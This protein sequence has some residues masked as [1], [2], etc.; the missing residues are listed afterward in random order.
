MNA[1]RTVLITVSLL[2]VA[3]TVAAQPLDL[4]PE[5]VWTERPSERPVIDRGPVG[6][7]DTHTIDSLFLFADQSGLY[8]FYT[9][10]DKPLDHG[11]R[12]RIGLAISHDGVHWEKCETN[13]VVVEGLPG[14][15]DSVGVKGPVVARRNDIYYL[16]YT[17]GDGQT[18]QIG[19]ATSI[20]LA[21][22]TKHAGNPVLAGRPGAWD[23][24]LSTHPVPVFKR[25]KRFH[26]LYRGVASARRRQGL[27][28]AVSSNLRQWERLQEEPV[29]PPEE[30]IAS[31][32]VVRARA[33]F[34]GIA[35]ASERAYWY[36]N[37][38]V[39]W[40][41]GGPPQFTGRNVGRLS[42][43]IL[44][45]GEWIMLYGRH[46]RIYRAVSM[47][48]APPA[49]GLAINEDNSHFFGS[50]SADEMTLEGLHAFVDQ[51]ASTRV[52]DLFLCPNAMRTS[53]RSEVWDPIW[54]VGDQQVPEDSEFAQ[55]WVSNARLLDERGLDPYAVWI[56]R[57]REKGIRPWLS[58]RMNDVHDV[59][60]LTSFM[61]STFW[62]EHPEYWRVPGSTGNW[63][64][65]AFDYAIPEV[66]EHHLKLIRELLE[67]YDPAGIELDWMRFGYHFKPGHEGEGRRILTE[68]ME[69]VHRLTDEWSGKRGHPIKLGARVPAHPDAAR[70][71]GMAAVAWARQGLVDMLV[72]T[73]FWSTSD[74]DIPME[75][76]RERIGPMAYKVVLA[77][78][79]EHNLRA[80]PAAEATR[81][82]LE[83]VRGFAVAA[84]H[85]DADQIYLFNYMDPAPLQ[86]GA[87]AYRVLLEQGLSFDTVTPLP[88]RHVVTYRD[89]VPAGMS[90]GALLPVDGHK[91]GTFRVYTGAI[92]RKGRVICRMGLAGGEKVGEAVFDVFLND[93]PC[94]P[95]GDH[96]HPEDFPGAARAVQFDCP[97]SAALQA[98]Y[99]TVRA[100]QRPGQP[101]Q[102]IVWAEIR[103]VPEA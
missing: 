28:V 58:V 98:G 21:R 101:E 27:G 16:F 65:R 13:P 86:G 77:A 74:F 22:W 97:W 39:N 10:Q 55:K 47:S 42:N 103:I 4:T 7:W 51:Y 61:H 59:H 32:A 70:G 87:E 41:K 93:A 84:F 92:P 29:I 54:E 96:A 20:N 67:R 25:E 60:D 73:P 102:Q 35:E 33:G 99:N 5:R 71:L 23:R 85:R 66:R 53:Y 3:R 38:L 37:D 52:T 18:E 12:E 40:R 30:E 1:G 56:A 31:L 79:L 6:A 100:S 36:S 95:V 72:P 75:L 64:D 63:V 26:L 11:G 44:C 45:G 82:D 15:W 78:G 81:N 2:A 24:S 19:L 14:S 49:L 90:N 46:G 76:W 62:L 48:P 89:T 9:G 88:R 69:E 57:C 91:G 50:R 83:S 68:S 8:C 43:P 94:E 34:V 80:Y 17:G